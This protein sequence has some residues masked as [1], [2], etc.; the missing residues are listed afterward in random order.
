MQSALDAIRAAVDAGGSLG[1]VVYLGAGRGA[2]LPAILA[3]SPQRLI[4]VEGDPDQAAVLRRRFAGYGRI[5][6]RSEVVSPRAG[7][8]AWHCYNLQRLN[9]LLAAGAR[10]R[11]AYPR[12]R[13]LETSTIETVAMEQWLDGL[14]AAE[15]GESGSNLLVFDVAGTDGLL[16]ESLPARQLDAFPWVVVRGAAEQLHASGSSLART[17][18]R[19]ERFGYHA[20]ATDGREALWPIELY[21]G[22]PRVRRLARV[23]RQLATA[24]A[25]FETRSKEMA[26]AHSR[27]QRQLTT[28]QAAL[29]NRS[30][31]LAQAHARMQDLR[32]QSTELTASLKAREDVLRSSQQRAHVLA[33]EKERL[34]V[35]LEKVQREH[36]A[37]RSAHGQELKAWT[38][39]VEKLTRELAAAGA[40]AK[41]SMQL[42]L[43]READLEDLRSR[44]E[45]LHGEQRATQELLSKLARRLR[46]A[47]DHLVRS[48]DAS[49]NPGAIQAEAAEVRDER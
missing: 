16:L 21:H 46:E 22:D 45:A 2:D 40:T 9:G 13:A 24:E 32:H 37:V 7:P 8:Q 29:E 47:T 11:E 12:L 5:E 14:Q 19:L 28:A 31:E 3:R 17:R 38:A 1:T 10:L 25:T 34:Q 49:S 44:F 23:Q 27:V 48:A 26:L 33:H 35:D 15:T 4:L 18:A 36:E 39:R 43:L 41:Q 42:R 30:K 20:V 6:V